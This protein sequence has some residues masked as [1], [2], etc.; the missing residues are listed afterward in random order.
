MDNGTNKLLNDFTEEDAKN[1]VKPSLDLIEDQTALIINNLPH[2]FKRT[3]KK[4]EKLRTKV[5]ATQ[6]V[7]KTGLRIKGVTYDST[8][9]AFKKFL[10]PTDQYFITDNAV[11]NVR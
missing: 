6:K 1:T 11:S 9:E 5:V 8:T 3:L 2:N 10:S 7:S 4:G